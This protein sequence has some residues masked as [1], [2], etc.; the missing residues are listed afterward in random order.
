MR[1]SL[2]SPWCYRRSD[3][4]I[5]N[6]PGP[7]NVCAKIGRPGITIGHLVLEYSGLKRR[8]NEVPRN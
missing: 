4:V 8:G 3:V 5:D 7:A 2:L 1:T 6:G